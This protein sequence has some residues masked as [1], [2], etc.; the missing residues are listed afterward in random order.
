MFYGTYDIYQDA[1]SF[2]IKVV[3]AEYDE[4]E[5]VTSSKKRQSIIEKLVHGTK[6][7]EARYKAFDRKFFKFPSYLRRSAISAAIGA[8]SSYRSNLASWE[9]SDK[10][11][12]RPRLK[13]NRNEMPVFYKGNMFQLVDDEYYQCRIKI[14]INNDWNWKLLRFRKTDIDYLEKKGLKLDGT[15]CPKLQKKGKRF[16]L[17]FTFQD[18]VQ[19]ADTKERILSCDIG[20]NNAAVVSVMEEDGTVLEREVYHLSCRRRP[21]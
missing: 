2:L 16:A 20:I 13:V 3:N 4:I 10:S 6:K 21:F 12:K 9:A 7:R 8:V 5:D 17:R 19:L 11:H 1:V 18:S 14:F 15:M